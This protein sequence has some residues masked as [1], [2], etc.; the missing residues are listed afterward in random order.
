M[1]RV[2]RFALRLPDLL[3]GLFGGW[4]LLGRHPWTLAGADLVYSG[5]LSVNRMNLVRQYVGGIL[6]LNLKNRSRRSN[7]VRTSLDPKWP[8]E[9]I[10]AVARSYR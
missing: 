8:A 7:L 5:Q 9:S 4:F 10:Y 3:R 1:L 6:G 2:S